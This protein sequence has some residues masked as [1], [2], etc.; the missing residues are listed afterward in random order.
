MTKPLRN[1]YL[2]SLVSV[3]QA[4]ARPLHTHSTAGLPEKRGGEEGRGEEREEPQMWATTHCTIGS[5]EK[6]G[7]EEEGRGEE[8]EEP[9]RGQRPRCVIRYCVPTRH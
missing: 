1:P 7:G 5:P 9:R 3:N 8:S 4:S 2:V 6:R